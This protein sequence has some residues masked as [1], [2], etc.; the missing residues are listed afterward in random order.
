MLNNVKW[1]KAGDPK[2]IRRLEKWITFN[3]IIRLLAF[4]VILTFT[5]VNLA[6]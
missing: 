4:L 1:E 2:N 6:V 3:L 5:S